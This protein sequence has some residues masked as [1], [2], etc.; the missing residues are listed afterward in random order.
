MRHLW[1]LLQQMHCICNGHCYLQTV[2]T[3]HFQT[4]S[5]KEDDLSKGGIGYMEFGWVN[6]F[7]ALIVIVML[8]PNILFAVKNKHIKNKCKSGLM[9]CIEQIGRYSCLV[10]IWFPLFVWKFGFSSVEKMLLYLF[11]NVILLL[12]YIIIWVFYFKRPNIK[13][14]LSLAVIPTMI[15]LIS[16][17]L[18]RHWLLFFAAILF[19]IGHIYVTKQN[20]N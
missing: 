17:V 20:Y 4:A 6:L 5:L 16:G 2:L 19:G 8:I 1:R 14:A 18:L 7:G 13:T 9:N 11:S 12:V 10:L 15:F 3:N